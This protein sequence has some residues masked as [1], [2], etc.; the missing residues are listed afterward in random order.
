[1]AADD[2]HLIDTVEETECQRDVWKTLRTFVDYLWEFRVR[3]LI[4]FAFLILAKVA[5][6]F[7]PIVL[8]EIVDSFENPSEVE[9]I[10][11]VSCISD[12]RIW[13]IASLQDAV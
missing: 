9:K 1:M 4:A 11:I 12:H 6:V 13:I 7:V 2:F 10:L 5:N 3:I 8:K